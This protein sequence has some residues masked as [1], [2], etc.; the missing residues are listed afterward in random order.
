MAPRLQCHLLGFQS[1]LDYVIIIIYFIVIFKLSFIYN[2][3]E[4]SLG[5]C[6]AEH[7]EG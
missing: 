5:H 7:A 3:S 1:Y 4:K 6:T 2:G